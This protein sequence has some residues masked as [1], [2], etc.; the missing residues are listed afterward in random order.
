[1]DDIVLVRAVMTKTADLVDA[2]P[3]EAWDRRTPCVDYDV[4]A[5]LRHMVGWSE[6]FAAGASGAAEVPDPEQYVAGPDAAAR[7]RA[8]ATQIIDGWQTHGTDRSVT[9]SGGE[10]PGAVVLTMTAMEYV[11]HGWDLAQGAGLPVPYTEEE[12]ADTLQ[13]AE[14]TLPAEYRGEGKAF[15][16]IVAVPADAPAVERLA[17][18]MGRQPS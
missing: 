7:F 9:L 18:F 10:A 13:R 12:A 17:G 6:V 3:A 2:V 5:L 16:E 11:T 4:R 15:G 1:M 14:A 8:A